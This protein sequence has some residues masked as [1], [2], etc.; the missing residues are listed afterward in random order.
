[1]LAA[2][3]D[4]HRGDDDPC[5]TGGALGTVPSKCTERRG[6][7]PGEREHTDANTDTRTYAQNTHTGRRR[8]RVVHG[9]RVDPFRKTAGGLEG[10]MRGNDGFCPPVDGVK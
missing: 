10:H 2:V 5:G 9:P 3:L 6:E 8:E 7:T 1:M 4:E